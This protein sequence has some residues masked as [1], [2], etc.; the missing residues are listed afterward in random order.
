M[1]DATRRGLPV[2]RG[3]L[4]PTP[5]RAPAAEDRLT[6][7]PDLPL[8]PVRAVV[9]SALVD[10]RR[11]TI[12]LE[13]DADGAWD[14][15]RSALAPDAP[16]D[17][18]PD[19]LADLL[20]EHE[21]ERLLVLG[22]PTGMPVEVDAHLLALLR[23]TRRLAVLAISPARRPLEV[24][25]RAEFGATVVHAGDLVVDADG[26]RVF[27]ARL[28]VTLDADQAAALAASPLALPDVLPA[29]VAS[30]SLEE[31]ETQGDAVAYL[32]DECE[33][34]LTMRFR[35]SGDANVLDLLP[36][37]VPSTLTAEVLG[38]VAPAL[39]ARTHL[40]R[41][42]QAGLVS[43]EPG[44]GEPRYRFEPMLRRVLVLE[45]RFRDA[46]LARRLSTALGRYFAD[47]GDLLAAMSHYGD[48]EDWDAVLAVLDADMFRLLADDP[49]QV[50]DAILAIPPAVRAAHPRLA[51]CLEIGWQPRE[52]TSRAYLPVARRAAGIF[53]RLPRE[54]PSW[55]RLHVLLVRSVVARL[56]GEFPAALEAADEL[57]RLL[58]EDADIAGRPAGTLAEAH[59][60]SA[61]TRLLGL[62]LVGA[63]AGFER[64][65]TLA[66][67]RGA[68]GDPLA[69]R[70]AEASALVR[71][72]E[73]DPEAAATWLDLVVAPEPGPAGV[74]ASAL[75]AIDSGDPESADASL[76]ALES[77][78]DLDELWPFAV[79]V[80]A[81]RGILSGDPVET[82]AALDAAWSEHREQLVPGSTAQA[83]LT[84]DAAEIA[85]LLGQL[86]RAESILDAVPAR[87][88]WTAVPRARMALLGGDAKHALLFILE[89]Q[90]RARTER[91][92]QLDLAVLRAVAELALDRPADATASTLRAVNT[93]R[94]TG[95]VAPFRMLTP[96][97]LASLATLAPEAAEFL[98][99]HRIAG[100]AFLAPY[101]SLAGA[102]SE[103]ELIVLRSLE[104]GETVEQIAK[105][106]F[107]ASNTVKAQL[108]SI[109]RK[110]GVSTRTEALLVA[111][112]LGLL[113]DG[114]DR[115][116]A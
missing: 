47:R 23:G 60:Q 19:E 25:G 4:A 14:A 6:I 64:S 49:A 41:M 82:D 32:L 34:Y 53:G 81:L 76:R 67:G 105:K 11:E 57:D 83:L 109:Y 75:V 16:A 55:D 102:L 70:A 97:H 59:F 115:R 96:A 62:D 103:R 26:I 51:L 99:E 58:D 7:V 52:G 79:H 71:A 84:A 116:S 92:G 89:G 27:S 69:D 40:D 10:E 12:W 113:D 44:A 94:K 43:R 73:R 29:V 108:R 74:L 95:V 13:P 48:G 9:A 20:A 46:A 8:V 28:G 72:L 38:L 85:L 87:T 15:I 63:R 30:A 37:S 88:T 3:P 91:H 65:F 1:P 114:P 107:V 66:Q 45:L 90:R 42:A 31:I 112:S 21:A 78:T 2:P 93:A 33:T 111:A 18:A 35:A 101:Q 80:A 98:A 5:F 56:K 39:A 106:L 110:L 36:L 54:L 50:H 61:M 100:G 68:S 22:I 77:A 86:A 104:P 17:L 24:L